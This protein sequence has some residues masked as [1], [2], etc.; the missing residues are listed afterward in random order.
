VDL[1]IIMT[2]LPRGGEIDDLRSPLHLE[3]PAWKDGRIAHIQSLHSSVIATNSNN[4]DG[5]VV[6]VQTRERLIKAETMGINNDLSS[7]STAQT[8]TL[9]AAE[10]AAELR[11]ECALLKPMT[12]F[13]PYIQPLCQ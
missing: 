4:C 13:A 2:S 1:K 8:N 10:I 6:S 9:W 7:G 12:S 5:V 3:D 11:E